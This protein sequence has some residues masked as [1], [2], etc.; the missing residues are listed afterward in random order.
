MSGQV[1][2]GLARRGVCSVGC[3]NARLGEPTCESS[4]VFTGSKKYYG[5]A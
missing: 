2:S 1:M 5:A 4:N 3:G